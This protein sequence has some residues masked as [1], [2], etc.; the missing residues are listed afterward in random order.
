MRIKLNGWQRI[1]IVVSL[2]WFL[3]FFQYQWNSRVQGVRDLYELES[4]ACYEKSS[5]YAEKQEEEDL[6]REKCRDKASADHDHNFGEARAE[7]PWLLAADLVTVVF[8]WLVAWIVVSITRW[9][10]RASP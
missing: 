4:I 1:A 8:G 9:I 3:G 6:K 5:G 10:R 7:I 2:I